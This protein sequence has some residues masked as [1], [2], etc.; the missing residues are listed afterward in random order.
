MKF[1]SI[2][3]PWLEY[4]FSVT[5]TF[6]F[7][8]SPPASSRSTCVF[9]F[10]ASHGPRSARS[11]HDVVIARFEVFPAR[12]LISGDRQ[13]FVSHRSGVGPRKA[14]LRGALK[15]CRAVD[16]SGEQL[17]FEQ[18]QFHSWRRGN[19]DHALLLTVIVFVLSL[20]RARLQSAP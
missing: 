7:K 20:I 1:Q 18:R 5:R 2:G 8:S 11:D 15:E 13:D 14:E 4:Q 10:S 6:G 19:V 17:R 16:L 9:R 3:P 12:S